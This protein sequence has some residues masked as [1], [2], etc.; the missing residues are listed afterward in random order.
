MNTHFPLPR[1]RDGH[2]QIMMPNPPIPKG[3]Y[4][5]DLTHAVIIL[6]V[7]VVEPFSVSPETIY[8]LSVLKLHINGLKLYVFESNL[9][10]PTLCF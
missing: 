5:P 7:F 2:L 1:S 4:L 10:Y 6:F 9:F 3:F 8:A